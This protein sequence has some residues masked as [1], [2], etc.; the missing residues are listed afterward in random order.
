M[1]HITRESKRERAKKRKRE[2]ARERAGDYIRVKEW[3]WHYFELEPEQNW[4]IHG[5]ALLRSC[6]GSGQA[7]LQKNEEER[8]FLR[9]MYIFLPFFP[10]TGELAVYKD[11]ARSKTFAKGPM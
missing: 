4:D 8:V 2:R 3:D 6:A 5:L 9:D 11:V 10:R 1:D 7:A